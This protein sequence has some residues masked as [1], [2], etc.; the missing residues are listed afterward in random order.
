MESWKDISKCYGWNSQKHTL[1]VQELRVPHWGSVAPGGKG[2]DGWLIPNLLDGNSARPTSLMQ[3]LTWNHSWA[4]SW[5]P[6]VAQSKPA[7][8]QIFCIGVPRMRNKILLLKTFRSDSCKQ[9]HW[10][11]EFQ[12]LESISYGFCLIMFRD[13]VFF[14]VLR[15]CSN[16]LSA[17]YFFFL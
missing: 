17:W 2:W 15:W 10:H 8:Y 11:K 13:I 5:P 12:K 7:L 14:W 1:P 6:M 16:M 4:F 9:Y 3:L